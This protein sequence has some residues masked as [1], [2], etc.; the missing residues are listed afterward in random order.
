MAKFLYSA[1]AASGVTMRGFVDAPSSSDALRR[2]EAEGMKEVVLH[3]ETTFSSEHLV[4]LS[5]DSQREMARLQILFQSSPGLLSAMKETARQWSVWLGFCLLWAI[6][7]M[8]SA[9]VWWAAAALCATALPFAWLAWNW[10][11]TGRYIRLVRA[12]ALGDWQRVR[13]LAAQLRRASARIP[14]M[15]FD[16]DVRL[17]C[18]DARDTALPNVLAR[19]EPWRNRLA[20]DPGF[21]EGQIARVRLAAGDLQ[22]VVKETTASQRARPAD[23]VR[24]LDLALA[25]A[26]FGDVAQA[27]V[28]F[29]GVQSAQLPP[30]A[31]GFLF[32]TRGLIERRQSD[33]KALTTLTAAVAEFLQCSVQPSVWTAIAVCTCDQA[34]ALH[35]AGRIDEAR[36]QINRVWP[37]LRVHA[38]PPLLVTLEV[39]GLAPEETVLSQ[40]THQKH[41]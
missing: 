6:Y 2:L 29:S 12:Y 26:R 31:A 28:L 4:R 15:D 23:A 38:Q 9:R 39:A 17:A 10:R 35:A 40:Q 33:P 19:L 18:I 32:W 14:T 5:D 1:T 13:T 20:A 24:L 11:H 34:I 3:N 22:G 21:Y 41:H 25:H 27:Q 36:R 37:V 7:A 30:H 8:W 16:L